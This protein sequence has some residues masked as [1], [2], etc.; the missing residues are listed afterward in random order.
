VK[1]AQATDVAV[2]GGGTI[3]LSVAWRLASEGVTVTVFDEAPGRGAS[4]AAGGMLAAVMEAEF[5]EEPLLRLNLASRDLWPGFAAL[6]ESASDLAPGYR[7]SGT[8]LVARDRDDLDELTGLRDFMVRLD[9]KV[10]RLAARDLRD[11][12]PSLSPRIRGGLLAPDDHRVDNRALVDALI[13]AC[14]RAGVATWHRRGG[15]GAR[16]PRPRGGGAA[17]P[18]GAP[19]AVEFRGGGGEE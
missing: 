5:G 13:V 14:E 15:G 1:S 7:Q 6:L 19:G 9:L 10:E 16:A 11:L 18:G 3:G 17:P 2:V 4:W 12:E 8:V